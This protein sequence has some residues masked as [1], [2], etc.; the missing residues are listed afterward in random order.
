M[1][2]TKRQLIE[3]AFS[4]IGL[5]SYVFDLTPD[6]LLGAM[7]RMDAMLSLWLSKGIDLGY[8]FPTA[9]AIGD[10]DDDSGIPERAVL[11]VAIN[12]GIGLGPTYGKQIPIEIKV[13]ARDAY[14]DVLRVATVIPEMALPSTLPVG[15]GAKEYEYPFIEG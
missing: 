3:M 6:Q 4:E 13:S 10:L 1:S 11:A 7:R 9:P 15:A 8:N 14:K 5:G 2:Y 12:L